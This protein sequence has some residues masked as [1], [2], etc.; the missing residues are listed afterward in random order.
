MTADEASPALP[1]P[2]KAEISALKRLVDGVIRAQ[3]NRFIKELLREK[4]IRIGDTK[5]DFIVNLHGAIE[6]GRLRLDAVSEWLKRVEGWGNQHVYL[7]RISPPLRDELT[8]RRVRQRVLANAELAELWDASTVLAFPDE[9]KL[10]S[11]SF[12]DSVLRLVWQEASPMWTPV[13]KK[14]FERQEGID[15]YEY[16]AFLWVERR[17]FTR[18]E[19]HLDK[20]IAGLFIPSPIQGSEHQAAILEAKRVIGLLMNL[21][22]LENEQFDI[23]RVSKNLD[24]Q[25]LPTNA[26]PTPGIKT[27]KSRL[28]SGGA[29][30]EFA[31]NSTDRAFWEETAV[32]NVRKSLGLAQL[33]VF[34]GTEGSFIFQV[35]SG[36]DVRSLRVQLYGAENRVRLWAQMDADD[37]WSILGQID[38]YLPR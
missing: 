2:T 18:F 22:A 10:T 25:N 15:L 28:T 9:P 27:Q 31:A 23:S 29:Y 38:T 1:P 19:A 8:P 6:D 5:E 14:N 4:E 3:G 34:Q 7:Y 11:I 36:P 17:I 20:G 24:Q 16:R 21:E 37:V 26:A 30:V 13:P 12:T 35:G 33:R 32:R